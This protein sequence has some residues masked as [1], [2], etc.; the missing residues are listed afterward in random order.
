MFDETGTYAKF[1]LNELQLLPVGWREEI[2]KVALQQSY[3]VHLD[4]NSTTSR[5]PAN[6][7]GTDINIV[8]G[9]KIYS[10]LPWLF[11][12]YANELL[13]LANKH[14]PNKYKIDTEL[15]SSININYLKGRGSR[16]ERHVDSNPLTGILF[17]T[18][19]HEPEGGELIFELSRG[20]I[21]ISPEPGIFILFDAR[22][23]PHTVTPLK[24][25]AYRISIPMNFFLEGEKRLRPSDLDGY[26]YNNPK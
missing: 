22:E 6:S 1:D 4:G 8:D 10:S 12:L 15:I 9:I 16:Y 14:F 7:K 17:V 2:E 26:I 19:H 18:S 3:L 5:E 13:T 23:L 11:R 25:S 20:V 24:K 21:K